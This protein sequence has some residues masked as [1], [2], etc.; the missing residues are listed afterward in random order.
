MRSERVE[1]L[2]VA[3]GISIFLVASFHSEIREYLHSL[4]DVIGLFRLPLFFF[5]SGVFLSLKNDF[6]RF[7]IRK[8]DA[9][10]KPYLIILFALGCF[11]IIFRGDSILNLAWI[12]Y[13]T[14][15]TI[16]WAPMWFLPHLF[17][18][19]VM[20]YLITKYFFSLSVLQNYLVIIVVFAVGIYLA[21]FIS[22]THMSPL[23]HGKNVGLPMSF[24][25]SL[26]SLGFF[27][28][29]HKLKDLVVSI[30]MRYSYLLASFSTLVLIAAFTDA[31]ID[32]NRMQFDVPFLALVASLCGIYIVF[33]VSKVL[34]L[35]ASVRVSFEV[36]G[37]SSLFILIFHYWIGKVSYQKLSDITGEGVVTA[38]ISFCLSLVIPVL[39][40]LLVKRSRYASYIF[41]PISQLKT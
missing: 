16:K 11:S 19:S 9:L 31:H 18:V 6:S 36:L 34:T 32:L 1:Y 14:A 2:D 5:V 41:L 29:G 10:L 22:S 8:F 15:E 26:I 12:L 33:I 40:W 25:V 20:G 38:V 30:E 24:E 7:C 17:I 21:N 37:K 27:L 3:K 39:M 23:L 13:G 28:L 35:T 4:F